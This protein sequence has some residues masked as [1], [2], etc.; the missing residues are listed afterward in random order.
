MPAPSPVS[1]IATGCAAVGE[2]DQHL[3]TLADN[4]VALLAANAGDQAHAAGIVLIPW[5]IEPLRLRNAE[6]C[7]VSMAAFS[8]T[9]SVQIAV[10]VLKD[11]TAVRFQWSEIARVIIKRLA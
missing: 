5:M 4:L 6:M 3:K 7:R 10:F 8:L 2:V 9:V 11:T 1:G